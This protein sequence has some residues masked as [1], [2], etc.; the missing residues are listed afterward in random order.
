MNF[1][2]LKTF[3]RGWTFYSRK[4]QTCAQGF[5]LQFQALQLIPDF[6]LPVS[7]NSISW[8]SYYL[9][10][11]PSTSLNTV[12]LSMIYFG[13]EPIFFNSTT[14][15]YCWLY[16]FCACHTQLVKYYCSLPFLLLL[17][18]LNLTVAV[19]NLLDQ[20]L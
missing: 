9:C 20:Q 11:S 2:H 8:I 5:T 18:A 1:Y 15:N 12:K 3:S 10:P 7:P 13:C 14:I 17:L 6:C 19:S 16:I 4:Y